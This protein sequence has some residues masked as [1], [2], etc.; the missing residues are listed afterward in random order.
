MSW[1]EGFRFASPWAF[2]GLLALPLLWWWLG[3]KR[4][5]AAVKFSSIGVLK[6]VG[7]HRGLSG[8]WAP[9]LLFSLGYTGLILALARPQSGETITNIKASGVDIMLA[10]DV[11]TSMEAMDFSIGGERVSRVAAVRKVTAEFIARRKNDRMGLLAFAGRPYVVSPLTL[12]HGWLTQN[13]QRTEIGL[14][15][16]DGTAIG[17]AIATAANRLKDRKSKSRIIVLLT[18]GTNNSGKIQP[19]TAAE[20]A[21]ALGIKVYTIG[22]GTRGRA[23][24]PR[25]G[26]GG[27]IVMDWQHVAFDEETLQQ[28][29]DK[30]GGRYFRATD[31]ASLEGIYEEIDKLE[32]TDEE[33]TQFQEFDEWFAWPLVPGVFCLILMMILTLTLWRRIP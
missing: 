32:R 16:Q 33:I 1:L 27:R 23:P 31:T 9:F 25:R 7:Q 10:L 8:G 29:A 22:A 21:E 30:T 24:V 12:D 20:A 11:S 26:F 13:L 17:S 5:A 4:G 18:D 14:V 15:Q 28:I 3:R 2:L 19:M 6:Q